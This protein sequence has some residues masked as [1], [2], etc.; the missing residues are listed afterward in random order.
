MSRDR[1]LLFVL[2]ALGVRIIFLVFFAHPEILGGALE[3]RD[4]TDEGDYHQLASHLAESGRYSLSLEGPSTAIRPPGTV[5][6]IAALYKLFGP[7]P[8]LGVAYVLLCSL[9]LVVAIGALAQEIDKTPFVVNAAM[10]IA[11][12]LPTAVFTS[13]GIWSDTPGMLFSLLAL[14]LLLV[15]RRLGGSRALV[16]V[17]GSSLGLAYLNR[18]SV[19]LLIALLSVLLLVEHRPRLCFR[20]SIVFAATAATPI[21]LWG[22]WNLSTLGSF[23]IGN[24]QS[25]VTLLQANNVVTAGIAPPAIGEAHGMD[26]YAEYGSGAYRGS[27]IP[28]AY[29]APDNPWSNRSLP[30]MA[31]ESWLRAEVSTFVREHPLA[32]LRLIAYKGLRILTAE[33]TP[34]SVLRES[35]RKRQLKRLVTF[36]E[37][38]FLILAGVPGLIILWR[39]QRGTTLYLLLY[40]ATGLTVALVAYPNARILFPV[41]VALIVPAAVALAEAARRLGFNDSLDGQ[42]YST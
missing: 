21:V 40:L 15:S 12:L 2:L 9:V 1:L 32:A 37:R 16:A 23:F 28:L 17:A 34:V 41:S 39:R 18:P 8:G 4:D 14:L 11:A 13:A 22:L 24:T 35:T 38:W 27:W 33:P 5:L 6:P 30:E 20:R 31:A 42:R 29:F 19:A 10:L 25:T 3:P 36:A 26:L 7:S